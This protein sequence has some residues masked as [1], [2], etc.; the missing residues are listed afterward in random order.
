MARSVEIAPQ[1]LDDAQRH[2]ETNLQGYVAQGDGQL[3]AL[4]GVLFGR[5][6]RAGLPL[7]RGQR[8]EDDAQRLAAYLTTQR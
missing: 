5:V 7:I 2:V 1:P 6:E 8:A 4:F 3:T